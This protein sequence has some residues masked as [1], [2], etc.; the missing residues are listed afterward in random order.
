MATNSPSVRCTNLSR[1]KVRNS[2]GENWLLASCN[3][4][5]VSENVSDVTVITEPAMAASRSRAAAGPP[6][7][8]HL[9]TS[10]GIAPSS[11]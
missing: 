5:R 2:R 6:P 8:I 9:E 4:T 7:K 1:A 11:I 3:V 10:A